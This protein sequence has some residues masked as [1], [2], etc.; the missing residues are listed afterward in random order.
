MKLLKT[1]T[2]KKMLKRNR[3]LTDANEKKLFELDSAKQA[4]LS[5]ANDLLSEMDANT[6]L[7]G[8]VCNGTKL[9]GEL[10]EQLNIIQNE[11]ELNIAEINRLKNENER[12]LGFI[13][14]IVRV[15]KKKT[16]NADKMAAI[17]K[18]LA[19]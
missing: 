12:M 3:E 7:A 11:H 19:Q 15:T 10:K 2:Y 8:Q 1:K 4:N 18:L 5:L 9:L 13:E 14:Q 17:K 16:S 6:R